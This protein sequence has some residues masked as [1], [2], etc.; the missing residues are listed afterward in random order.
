VTAP[1]DRALGAYLEAVAERTPAPGGG[2]AAAVA[3]ALAAACCAMAARFSERQLP[4][5]AEIAEAADTIRARALHLADEDA[6]AY[7]AVLAARRLPAQLPV[8]E[9]QEAMADAMAM[10]VAIPHEISELGAELARLATQ[11]AAAGNQNLLGDAL[12]A[13]LLAEAAAGAAA[14]LVEINLAAEAG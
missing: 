13:V 2:A 6:N 5:A 14:T 8:A 1:A 12:A 9:R 7:E 10:A 3:L 11:V 4:D